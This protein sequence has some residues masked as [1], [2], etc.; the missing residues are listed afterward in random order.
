MVIV[1]GCRCGARVPA[2]R[3]LRDQAPRCRQH[4]ESLAKHSN[5]TAR[6]PTSACP[7]TEARSLPTSRKE[8]ERRKR[9]VAVCES[10]EGHEM[11]CDCFTG[12]SPF[13]ISEVKACDEESDL[14][15]RTQPSNHW[16]EGLR[17]KHAISKPGPAL[18]TPEGRMLCMVPL[19]CLARGISR[20]RLQDKRSSTLPSARDAPNSCRGNDCNPHVEKNEPHSY[21]KRTQA[22]HPP[23]DMFTAT[24][25][26]C[27]R[28]LAKLTRT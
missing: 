13:K 27:I 4:S 28:Y 26:G 15:R 5:S 8:S 19:S 25:C 14:I 10:L 6:C 22:K 20:P 24:R 3:I 12:G 9:A 2:A 18:Q 21:K 23:H 1:N 16:R 17:W 7:S 11:E